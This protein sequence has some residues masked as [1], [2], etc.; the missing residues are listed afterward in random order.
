MVSPP[1]KMGP[2]DYPFQLEGKK[3]RG[4]RLCEEWDEVLLDQKLPDAQG[5]VS[6]CIAVENQKRFDLTQKKHVRKCYV[7]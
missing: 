4:A 2:F 1:S 3:S 5:I 7:C 6:R